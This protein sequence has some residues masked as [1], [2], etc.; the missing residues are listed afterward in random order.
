MHYVKY[1]C[2][3]QFSTVIHQIGFTFDMLHQ[4]CC[5]NYDYEGQL[6]VQ[7]FSICSCCNVETINVDM[8]MRWITNWPSLLIACCMA[9]K[10][11]SF[12]LEIANVYGIGDPRR[13]I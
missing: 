2:R 7:Y 10:E 1:I 4:V 3:G 12:T 8:N 9:N 11:E 6:I 5:N 13:K